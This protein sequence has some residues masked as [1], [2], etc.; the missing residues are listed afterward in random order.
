[1]HTSTRKGQKT[2]PS[3]SSTSAPAQRNLTHNIGNKLLPAS[4]STQIHFIQG[5]IFA[6]ERTWQESLYDIV[7]S[8]P[9]YVSSEGYNHTTTR[10]VR[11]H[12]PKLA[13]VPSMEHDSDEVGDAFYPR[14]ISLAERMHA[15]MIAVEVGDMQQAGRITRMI[16]KRQVWRNLNVWSDGVLDNGASQIEAHHTGSSP[17]TVHGTGEGRA[18]AAWK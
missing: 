7:V 5:D 2:S 3:A 4:A 11:N 10:S 14:I 6:E 1:M 15:I 18:V 17:F 16:G 13:L 8:N 12:E 9:P